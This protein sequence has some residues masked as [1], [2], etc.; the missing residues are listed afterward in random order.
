[1]AC[2]FLIAEGR[3]EQRRREIG[4]QRAADLHRLDRAALAVPPPISFDDLAQGQAE[5]AS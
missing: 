1:L 4:A 3:V 5:G 2:E